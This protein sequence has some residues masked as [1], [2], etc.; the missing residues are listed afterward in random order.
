MS[1]QEVAQAMRRHHAIMVQHLEDLVGYLEKADTAWQTTRDR[2]AGYLVSNVLPHAA[3]EES[4]IYRVGTALESL[5]KLIESMLFEHAVIRDLAK[6]LEGS[7]T[8]GQALT[9]AASAAKLFEVHAEKEN[10]F[11][12][13]TLEPRAD[14]D[15]EAV[16]GD[17]HQLLGH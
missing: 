9:L 13:A 1:N 16:L 11:I 4:T 8:Q 10:R 17:M 15:L 6:S 3:A 12:I 7:R 2:V 14:V 5:T